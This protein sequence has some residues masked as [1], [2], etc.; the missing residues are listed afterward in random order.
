MPV[1]NTQN[2]RVARIFSASF[3][4][5]LVGVTLDEGV[6]FDAIPHMVGTGSFNR[7]PIGLCSAGYSLRGQ[8]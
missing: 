3:A 8:E 7:V 2:D 4:T 6:C 1:R 5:T